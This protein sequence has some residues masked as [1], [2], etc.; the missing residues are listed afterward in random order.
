MEEV[1]EEF[2]GRP[3]G[4][5]SYGGNF[6]T[7]RYDQRAGSGE[8]NKVLESGCT[9]PYDV[10]IELLHGRDRTV[11]LHGSK[12]LYTISKKGQDESRFFRSSGSLPRDR[13]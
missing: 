2:R 5:G 7:T 10:R 1:S 12:T 3:G 11:S 6:G 8:F 4:H 13:N 9:M